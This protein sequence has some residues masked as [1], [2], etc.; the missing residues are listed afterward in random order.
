MTISATVIC[1]SIGPNSRRLVTMGTVAPKFI[2]QEELRH[3]MFS[4]SVSSARAIPFKK[5]LEEA[6]DFEL[7]AKPFKWGTEQKGMSPGDELSPAM[8]GSANK[9]WQRAA[10]SAAHHARELSYLGVHKSIVNRIIEPYI[11]VHVL[12]TAT[13]PGWMNFFG[14]R[15]DRAADPTLRALAEEMWKAWNESKPKLLQ[16]GEWH[17]PFIDDED[18]DA[19]FM[20]PQGHITPEEFNIWAT[21]VSV[22]RCARLSYNSFETGKRSTIEEDLKL[23]DRLITSRPIHA[24]PAEHQATPDTTETSIFY[25]ELNN[26]ESII[27]VKSWKNTNLHGNLL[28]WIQYRK[29]LPGESL[30]PLPEGY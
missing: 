10:L 6:K 29:T 13:E 9:A 12:R 1:D 21:K 15:L 19:M 7:Q 23:Y 26:P 14:L 20:H 11:H 28:D 25:K 4:F 30:A 24:S 8:A 17:L 27:G 5:L 2:H 22:A 3:R 16:P 18:V